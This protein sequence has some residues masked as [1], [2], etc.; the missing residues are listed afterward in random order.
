MRE[1][2][3]IDRDSEDK[4]VDAMAEQLRESSA[5]NRL[6]RA[7]T[8]GEVSQ[9]IKAEVLDKIVTEQQKT[10]NR[11][12]ATGRTDL[13]SLEE[14]QAYIDANAKDFLDFKTDILLGEAAGNPLKKANFVNSIA[15]TIAR[16][17]DAVKRSVYANAAADKFDVATDIIFSRVKLTREK[18]LEDERRE[19]LGMNG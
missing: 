5:G 6:N 4:S 13:T 19:N 16:I 17:P 3:P 14:V 2:Y 9:A 10:L 1:R 15:D 18:L 12:S 7:P 11:V 8:Y